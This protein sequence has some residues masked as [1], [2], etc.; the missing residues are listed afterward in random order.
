MCVGGPTDAFMFWCPW[1]RSSVAAFFCRPRFAS[2]RP[3]PPLTAQY[4][5]RTGFILKNQ[6]LEYR[7][8]VTFPDSVRTPRAR[9][10]LTGR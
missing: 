6:F 2:S 5:R 9:A 3:A 8:P 7:I 10:R 4:A 1:L